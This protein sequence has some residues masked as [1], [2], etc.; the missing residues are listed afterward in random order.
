LNSRLYLV[1][2]FCI[3]DSSGN[4]FCQEIFD[5]LKIEKKYQE[6]RYSYVNDDNH[7]YTFYDTTKEILDTFIALKIDS[8]KR[9]YRVLKI[10]SYEYWNTKY[11]LIE[12]TDY[13]GTWS[14]TIISENEYCFGKEKIKINNLYFM[15]IYY[16]ENENTALRLPYDSSVRIVLN[17][18]VVWLDSNI[19]KTYMVYSPNIKGRCFIPTD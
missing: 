1:I 17:N 11:N 12:I 10:Y 4:L 13:S 8:I 6:N 18:K 5:S 14:W 3:F 2:I 19:R 15:T 9:L 16:F 7:A